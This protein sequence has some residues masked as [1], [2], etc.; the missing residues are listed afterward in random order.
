MH[1]APK[2][3]H[4]T[5]D[6]TPTII[7]FGTSAFSIHVLERLAEHGIRPDHIVTVQDRPQGRKLVMTPP[8]V[9]VWAEAHGIP[10]LQFAKLDNDA[11]KIL[12]VVGIKGNRPDLFIVASYGKIIP[13]TVLDI[14]QHGSLNVH[15]SLLPKYR[16]ASPL[17]TS[18]LEDCRDT[19]VVI[20]QM[21]K[22][23]DHGPIVAQKEVSYEK[24]P[25]ALHELEQDL[26]RHGADI[27][28]Y[29]LPVYLKGTTKLHVQ[30]HSQATFTKKIHKEDG[31]IHLNELVGDVG[32]ATYLR[33]QAFEGWPSVYFFTTKNDSN[34]RVKVKAVEWDKETRTL[35]LTRVTP[36]GKKEMSWIEFK[37]FIAN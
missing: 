35:Y 12:S 13:Q 11:V 26:A 24:W 15:P 36:E 34:M 2:K 4:K 8:P 5:H 17:Q 14:P 6:T 27:L 30:D 16:G 25:L 3:M 20:I 31:E 33:F 10:V 19:G 9:K 1:V 22:E 37:N 23:M 21:D 28:A 32:Y 29:V 18:I 7:F